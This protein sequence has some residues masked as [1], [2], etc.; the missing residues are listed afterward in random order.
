MATVMAAA[1]RG[2]LEIV[3]GC[4]TYYLFGQD[5]AALE[6]IYHGC[7]GDGVEGGLCSIAL[8]REEDV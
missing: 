2:S 8:S 4:D 1:L 5:P 6:D 7:L 3:E